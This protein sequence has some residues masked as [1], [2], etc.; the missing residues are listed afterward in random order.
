MYL[1]ST[2][3]VFSRDDGESRDVV[4]VSRV[5]LF[6]D[7]ADALFGKRTEV[8]DSHDRYANI[9]VNY[10]LQ[11]LET[12]NGLAILATNLAGNL[13]EAFL[14][15]VRIRAEFAKPDAADRRRIWER[16]LPEDRAADV[17][18]AEKQADR[19]TADGNR[20]LHSAA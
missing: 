11:R 9:T 20:L 7:E 2:D 4:D 16:L 3:S 8:K 10:L 14:R 6:F 5:A 19:I 12:F 1:V 17:D 13:D 18:S 15:R